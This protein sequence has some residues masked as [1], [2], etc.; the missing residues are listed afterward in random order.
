MKSTAKAAA[1]MRQRGHLLMQVKTF[2][3][4]GVLRPCQPEEIPRAQG[5]KGRQTKAALEPMTER[6]AQ[7]VDEWPHVPGGRGEP[8]LSREHARPVCGKSEEELEGEES[9]RNADPLAA[10]RSGGAHLQPAI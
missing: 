2:G 7:E 1:Q 5:K 6:E 4:A 9:S 10:R 8:P 3:G